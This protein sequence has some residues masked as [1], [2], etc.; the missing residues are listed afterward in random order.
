MKEILLLAILL[1]LTGC[2]DNDQKSSVQEN[3]KRPLNTPYEFI[4]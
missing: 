4:L 2:S 3:S 1:G